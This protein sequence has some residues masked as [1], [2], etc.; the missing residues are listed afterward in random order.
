MFRSHN[1]EII[2]FAL[3][4]FVSSFN[5]ATN[6]T[7]FSLFAQK[8]NFSPQQTGIL[9]GTLT[10]GSMVGAPFLGKLVDRTGKRKLILTLGMLGQGMLIL[11]TPLTGSF[12][13][14]T[15]MRFLLGISIVV[16][17]P[18]LNELIVNLEDSQLRERSLTFLSIARSIGFSVGCMVSGMLMDFSVAWNFYFSALLALGIT[19]P[20]VKFIKKADMIHPSSKEGVTGLKWLFEKRILAHYLSAMLRAT[21]VMGV[22]FFL[23]LFWQNANQSAT[24]SGTI[25]GLANFFQIIFFPIARLTCSRF[26]ERSFSIALLGYSTS[27]VP[28]YVF[29]FLKGWAVLLPQITMSMSFVFFY[30]GAIFSIRELV[31]RP[32]QTEAMGWLETFIN[33]GGTVGPVVF[34]NLLA[35]NGNDFPTTIL[36]FSIVPILAMA[37]FICARPTRKTN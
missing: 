10:A 15:L 34:A 26:P 22:L 19:I 18:V 36:S 35:L 29:P 1:L 31:P 24:S 20:A 8:L 9:L 27:I 37:L 7:L 2:T 33:L 3:I 28:F 13:L 32:H 30:I 25:I 11:L 16:Q 5:F 23:P 4:G 12:W 17:A 14:L 6:S 21:A